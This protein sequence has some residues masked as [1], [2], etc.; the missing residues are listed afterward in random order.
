MKIVVHDY[1]GHAF[2]IQLSRALAAR[3]HTVRHIYSAS[4]QTPKGALAPRPDDAPGFAF[5]PLD[6]GRP[7]AKYDLVRRAFQ[8]RAYG[9][10]LAKAIVAESPD[11]V[12]CGNAPLDPQAIALAA[13]RKH[14]LP[15][16]YWQQDIYGIA[17]DRIL[18]RK[19]P[20]VGA[21][22]AAHYL[23]LERRLQRESDRVVT[24]SD[25]FRPILEGWGVAPARIEVVENWAPL[26]DLPL[27]PRDNAWA[28]E[29]GLADKRVF[30]YSGTLGLKHNPGL[31]LALA[32]RFADRPDV[33]LVVVS[34]GLGADWL[35]ERQA[36]APNLVL[37][38]Y[39]PFERLADVV[40]SADVLVAILEPDAGVFSVP[41]KVLTYLCAGKPIL[42]A[43]PLANLASRIVTRTG[44]GRVA[45]PNDD[46]G[47]LAAADSLASDAGLRAR[48]G[49]AARVYAESHFAIGPIAD[50]FEAM[51]KALAGGDRH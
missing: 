20:V 44:A 46:A 38:P 42:A 25:D 22:I 45:E 23:R 43:I 36:E 31:L 8:E 35:R 30:L 39:Q 12:I 15:F 4:F 16:V 9:R 41:S 21:L 29:H 34:E 19:L 51:A 47:F 13:C 33:R 6:L 18:R 26:D 24:I 40:A 1:S 48:M 17:I 5:R 27:R 49:A 3:G 32:K 10:L 37:L 14:R 2:P 11:V 50:R 7:F 28:R